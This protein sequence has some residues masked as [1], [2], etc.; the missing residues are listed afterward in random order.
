MN[1]SEEDIENNLRFYKK[2]G[3]LPRR[4]E[5]LAYFLALEKNGWIETEE[6]KEEEK[7]E[8]KE[9]IAERRF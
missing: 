9:E 7:Q 4:Q 5:D 8:L 2:H 6:V 1:F 3:T